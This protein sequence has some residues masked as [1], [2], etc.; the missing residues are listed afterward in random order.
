MLPPAVL[1]FLREAG[2]PATAGC[3]VQPLTAP[4]ARRAAYRLS[5]G[6]ENDIKLRWVPSGDVR[7][8]MERLVPCLDR[9]SCPQIIAASG[10]CLIEQWLPGESLQGKAIDANLLEASGRTLARVHCAITTRVVRLQDHRLRGRLKELRDC[11]LALRAGGV[12][13]ADAAQT[14]LDDVL[15]RLPPTAHWGLM[16]RDFMPGNLIVHQDRVASIDN[17]DVVP[18]F[19]EEDLA[20]TFFRWPLSAAE[21][22]HF[23]TGYGHGAVVDSW[24]AHESFWTTLALVAVA[25]WRHRSGWPNVHEPIARLHRLHLSTR[26]A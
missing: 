10:R 18:G 19:L 16:H 20:L 9:E 15:N 26:A 24:I 22:G 7:R 23:L 14:I 3:D 5:S 13:G 11:V 25:A 12:L 4:T 21:Q 1:S 2:L 17:V 6:A 8:R